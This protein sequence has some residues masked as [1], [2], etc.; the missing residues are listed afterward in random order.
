MSVD[1]FGNFLCVSQRRSFDTFVLQPPALGVPLPIEYIDKA[2]GAV[3]GATIY[4]QTWKEISLIF[5]HDYVCHNILD[6]QFRFHKM[7][8]LLNR[9]VIKR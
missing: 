6:L 7:T 5:Q 2:F 8:S 1:Q 9:V 4:F 3:S